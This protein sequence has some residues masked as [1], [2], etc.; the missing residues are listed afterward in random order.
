MSLP[1]TS[2]DLPATSPDTTIAARLRSLLPTGMLA[3]AAAAAATVVVAALAQ[4]ADVSLEV[5]G[6]AIPLATFAFWT[7]VATFAGVVLA[8][9]VRHRRRFVAAT[10]TLTAISLVPSIV[11]PDDTATTIVL[12][13][14]HLLAAA[15]IIPAIS[16]RLSSEK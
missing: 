7:I 11:A 5:D 1:T 13:G 14:T 8:A 12:V 9:V 2:V 6:Q 10:L 3:G 4:A 16:I 15:I